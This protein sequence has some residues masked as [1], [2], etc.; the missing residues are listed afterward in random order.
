[1]PKYTYLGHEVN[2]GRFGV[3][4]RGDVVNLTDKEE[5]AI[6]E[7]KDSRFRTHKEGEKIEYA[8]ARVPVGFTDL[9]PGEQKKVMERIARDEARQREDLA[10][11]TDPR[12]GIQ[13]RG[14]PGQPINADAEEEARR[15]RLDKANDDTEVERLREM[16]K[17]ELVEEK[18]RMERED[19]KEFP[20]LNTKSTRGAIL[21]ELLTVKGFDPGAENT[22]DDDEEE[23]DK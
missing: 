21:R 13:G 17:A 16:T 2:L 5:D 8:G 23:K 1:M 4:R 3:V 7:S 22:G 14:A 18:E 12:A 19:G 9:K 11:A 15:E 10:Q 20:N 6:L